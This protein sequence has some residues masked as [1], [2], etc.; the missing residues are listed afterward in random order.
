MK[1][2]GSSSTDYLSII[3]CFILLENKYPLAIQPQY[4]FDIRSLK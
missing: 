2:V 3:S 4:Q 1:G